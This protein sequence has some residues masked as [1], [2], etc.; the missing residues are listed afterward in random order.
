M[1]LYGN[2]S[3]PS[4]LQSQCSAG[5]LGGIGAMGKL[6]KLSDEVVDCMCVGGLMGGNNI[7][8]QV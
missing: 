8:L 5:N 2:D 1:K 6:G 7:S 3:C 4:K